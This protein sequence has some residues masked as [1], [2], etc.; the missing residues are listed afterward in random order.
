MHVCS[1]HVDSDV[2]RPLDEGLGFQGLPLVG[3]P[4]GGLAKAQL[5]AANLA[6]VSQEPWA[7]AETWV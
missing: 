6:V 7:Q 1:F 5:K 4:F 2:F 3:V